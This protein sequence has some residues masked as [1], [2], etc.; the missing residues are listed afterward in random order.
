[1]LIRLATQADVEACLALDAD[2]QT[3]HVWQMDQRKEGDG[4]VVRFQT[5]RLPRIMRVAYPRSRDDLLACLEIG[6]T[7]LVATDK[8]APEP[9]GEEI[10]LAEALEPPQ[11]YGFCQLDSLAWQRTCWI[12]HLAVDRR[13][14]RRD[15]G[16]ALVQASVAWGRHHKFERLMIAVQTKNYPGISFCEKRGFTFCGF[17]DQY[18]PNRDIALFFSLRI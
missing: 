3:D 8:P 12:S 7:I 5:V 13:M 18:F 9:E 11:I 14:R 10:E 6:S 17:N 16:S 15:I 2:S 1:M 4:T